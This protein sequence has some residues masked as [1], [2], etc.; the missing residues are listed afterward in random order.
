MNILAIDYGS[1]NIG[2]ARTSTSV[3]V[4][5]PFGRLENKN[6]DFVKQKLI[7]TIT[8]EKID[9]LVVGLPFGLDGTENKNTERI[10]DFID[11]L[12]KQ[13]DIPIEFVTEVFSSQAGDRMGAGVSRDEKAAMIIL[14]NYL[15]KR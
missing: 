13:I 14:Q 3:D 6:A 7:E 11:D 9:K 2:L 15:V 8:K 4:V 1:K 5:L 10:R 12:K